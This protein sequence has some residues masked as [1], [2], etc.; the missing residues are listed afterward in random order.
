[1]QGQNGGGGENGGN[2]LRMPGWYTFFGG[3]VETDD[4]EREENNMGGRANG[5][6]KVRVILSGVDAVIDI[7]SFHDDIVST[8]TY[9]RLYHCVLS[10]STFGIS[11]CFLFFQCMDLEH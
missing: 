9:T 11:S 6:M 4:R 3:R 7:E 5:A 10:S 2:I 1:M 8:L